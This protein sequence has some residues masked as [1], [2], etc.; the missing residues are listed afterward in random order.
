MQ[1]KPL[2]ISIAFE[3][4]FITICDRIQRFTASFNVTF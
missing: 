4:F 1:R 3:N 2:Q